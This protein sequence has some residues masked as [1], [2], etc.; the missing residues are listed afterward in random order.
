MAVNTGYGARPPNAQR[1][2]AF[3]VSPRSFKR[4][5]DSA[6]PPPAWIRSRISRPRTDPTRQGV[7]FPQDS[8]AVKAMKCR[9]NSTMFVSS[10]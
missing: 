6:V 2:V 3:M 7:H 9:A 8:S 5:N 10:S 1:L 4:S